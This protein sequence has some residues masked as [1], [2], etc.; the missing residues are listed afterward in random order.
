[1]NR[2]NRQTGRILAALFLSAML[3]GSILIKPVHVLFV[4]HDRTEILH[5]HA[6]HKAVSTLHNDDCAICDFEFCSFIPQ[7]QVIVPQVNVFSFKELAFRTVACF[8]A[9]SSNDFQLRAPPVS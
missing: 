9:N 4:H 1:M 3:V 8:V 6:S 7:K 2:T 5:D